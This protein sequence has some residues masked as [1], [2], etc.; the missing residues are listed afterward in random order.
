[1][2]RP[3]VRVS[4]L[5]SSQCLNTAGWVTGRTPGQVTNLCDLSPEVLMQEVEEENQGRTS[6]SGSPD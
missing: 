5:H 4:A 3:L 6:S 2:T 1:V